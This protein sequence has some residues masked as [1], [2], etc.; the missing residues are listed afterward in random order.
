MMTVEGVEKA[1]GTLTAEQKTKIGDILSKAQADMKALSSEDRAKGRE[2][3]MTV[4]KDVR[5]V[6]TAEQQA[7]FDEMMPAGKGGK[8]KDN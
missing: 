6:L 1:V 3:M 2:M 8:K 5:A 7:K 4:R